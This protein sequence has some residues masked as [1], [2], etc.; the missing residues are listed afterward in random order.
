MDPRITKA[1]LL[2]VGSRVG[3]PIPPACLAGQPPPATAASSR[4]ASFVEGA[5]AADGTGGPLRAAVTIVTRGALLEAVAADSELSTPPGAEV[6]DATGLFVIPGLINSH[7]H[8]A[9]SP[10]RA[11]AEAMLRRNLYHGITAVR[12]MAGDARAL[13]DLARAALAGEIPAADVYYS[14]VMGGPP[15]FGDPR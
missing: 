4:G 2:G 10:N 13:A 15:L 9:T 11:R 5:G 3:L 12:D 6:V 7:V 1:L 8:L 14:A